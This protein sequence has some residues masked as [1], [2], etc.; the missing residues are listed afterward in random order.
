VPEA[1]RYPFEF[2]RRLVRE[3]LGI[4][5]DETPGGHL[6]ALSQPLELANRLQTYLRPADNVS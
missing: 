5:L 4:E 2:Q 1:A 6:L 3:R